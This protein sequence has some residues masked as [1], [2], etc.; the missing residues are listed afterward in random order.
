MLRSSDKNSDKEEVVSLKDKAE[1]FKTD[2][3]TWEFFLATKLTNIKRS[4]TSETFVK[5]S[6]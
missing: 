6:V 5:M 4:M 2:D 3:F 1:I